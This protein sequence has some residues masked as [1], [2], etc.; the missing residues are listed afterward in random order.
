VQAHGRR[1]GMEEM[2]QAGKGDLGLAPCETRSWVGWR[3]HMTLSM[4]A[5]WFLILFKDWLRRKSRH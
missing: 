4:L 2:L 3:H 1:H 5:F